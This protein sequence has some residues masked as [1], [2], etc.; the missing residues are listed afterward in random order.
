MPLPS[1]ETGACPRCRGKSKRSGLPCQN[2][3]AYGCKTCRI[4]GAHKFQMPRLAS[5]TTTTGMAK[6]RT[7]SGLS[8]LSTQRSF[9][10]FEIWG[11][12]S[13]S[14]TARQDGLDDGR[15]TLWFGPWVL[16]VSFDHRAHSPKVVGSNPAPATNNSLI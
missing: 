1:V 15:D 16:Q 4:H 13:G 6:P 8:I 11:R 12:R 14:L 2:P 3:A 9:I 5:L 7:W 10:G